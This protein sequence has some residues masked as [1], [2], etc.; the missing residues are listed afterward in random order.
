M[1]VNTIQ[2]NKARKTLLHKI[3]LI[4]LCINEMKLEE[5]PEENPKEQYDEDTIYKIIVA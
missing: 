4:I 3:N 1:E 2:A 5:N